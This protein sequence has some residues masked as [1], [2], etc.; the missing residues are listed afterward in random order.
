MFDNPDSS[1]KIANILIFISDK[2]DINLIPSNLLL[3][4]RNINLILLN[5]KSF[6]QVYKLLKEFY[7]IEDEITKNIGYFERLHPLLFFSSYF[8]QIIVPENT[9]VSRYIDTWFK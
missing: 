5:E 4:N 7:K 9:K 1:F 3:L 8:S 6:E 2:K